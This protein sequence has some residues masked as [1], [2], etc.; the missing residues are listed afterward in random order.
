[1]FACHLR[2]NGGVAQ[3]AVVQGTLRLGNKNII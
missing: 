2:Q 1:L 3:H